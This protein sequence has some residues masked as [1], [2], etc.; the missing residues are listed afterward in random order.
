LTWLAITGGITFVLYGLDKARARSKGWRV[1][2]VV[3]HVLALSGGFAGGWVGRG[4][5]RHKTRKGMFTFIL[6]V[7]A[8]LHAVLAYRLLF[9]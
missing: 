6:V 8:L 7:S 5:F 2:E 3:L 9:R 4:V 1:P